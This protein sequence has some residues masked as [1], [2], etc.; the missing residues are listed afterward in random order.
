MSRA[1][2]KI[3]GLKRT[4]VTAAG[5]LPVLRGIDLDVMPG[6]NVGLID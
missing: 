4:Y 3:R 1:V 6:E 5:S 2:L